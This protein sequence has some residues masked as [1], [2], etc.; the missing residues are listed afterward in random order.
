MIK[1]F[2]THLTGRA[3][4]L[5]APIHPLHLK[6]IN[7]KPSSP[8]PPQLPSYSFSSVAPLVEKSQLLHKGQLLCWVGTCED[9]DL[10]LLYLFVYIWIIFICVGVILILLSSYLCGSSKSIM[11]GSGNDND[12]WG[13]EK[14]MRIRIQK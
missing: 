5:E 1:I 7:Y 9:V 11:A 12:D 14:V 13:E 2:C 4:V 3:L 10:F 8:F 6:Y